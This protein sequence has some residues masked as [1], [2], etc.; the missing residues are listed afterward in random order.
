MKTDTPKSRR[1]QI[2]SFH[3][4][5]Q[6]LED[7]AIFMLD[8]EGKVTSWNAGAEKI[9]GYRDEEILGRDL[10]TIFTSED[11]E[12]GGPEREMTAARKDGRADD[13]RW[14]KRKN[15]ELFWASGIL[16]AIR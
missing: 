7:F 9:F 1:R 4:I 6:N 2:D 11:V 12:G 3:S 8:S 15:G 5:F 16:S 13:E 14:H 10:V